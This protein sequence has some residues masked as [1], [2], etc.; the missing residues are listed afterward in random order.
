[1]RLIVA[2][3]APLPGTGQPARAAFAKTNVVLS[4]FLEIVFA[5]DEGDGDVMAVKGSEIDINW[6]FAGK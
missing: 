1:M 5:L 3:I 4:T 2:A 6:S